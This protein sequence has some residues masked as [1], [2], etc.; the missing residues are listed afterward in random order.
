MNL[1]CNVQIHPYN[2]R[3]SSFV[4]DD[5]PRTIY[6]AH[7]CRVGFTPSANAAIYNSGDRI[8]KVFSLITSCPLAPQ[9]SKSQL[10]FRLRDLPLPKAPSHSFPRDGSFVLDHLNIL[11]YV[12]SEAVSQMDPHMQPVTSL[13]R[14][15]AGGPFSS[16]FTSG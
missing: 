13:F 7:M 4:P 14:S 12:P 3:S 10:T 8:H 11:R 1:N 5:Y 6:L 15:Y 9:E 2:L 16:S